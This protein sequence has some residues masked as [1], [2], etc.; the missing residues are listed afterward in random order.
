MST[1]T[2]PDPPAMERQITRE[3]PHRP[4]VTATP[5]TVSP[6]GQAPYRDSSFRCYISPDT[7][8]LT[9][10]QQAREATSSKSTTGHLAG[11]LR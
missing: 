2:L 7:T 9:R 3:M 11:T 1:R 10:P 8:I 6:P 4:H 5:V